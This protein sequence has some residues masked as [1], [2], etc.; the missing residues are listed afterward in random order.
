MCSGCA[1]NRIADNW[2]PLEVP[3]AMDF[4]RTKLQDT[5]YPKEAH[6]L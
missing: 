2:R 3:L 4:T 1:P 5:S 6:A